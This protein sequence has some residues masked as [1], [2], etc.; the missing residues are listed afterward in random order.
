MVNG[1]GRFIGPLVPVSGDQI[2]IKPYHS[3]V[4]ALF[5]R[6]YP[7]QIQWGMVPSNLR[8]AAAAAAKSLQSCPTLC[9]PI[10]GSP[11]G[12]PVP[13]LAPHERLPEL[14]VIPRAHG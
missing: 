9:D 4:L 14:P 12:S 7:F 5:F 6:R 11:P 2:P 13:A 8:V 10:D 3:M 1:T